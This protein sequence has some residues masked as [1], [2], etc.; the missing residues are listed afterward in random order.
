MSSRRHGLPLS[1]TSHLSISA[2]GCDVV[3]YGKLGRSTS[4]MDPKT[5]ATAMQ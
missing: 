4:E 1:K 5:E 3:Q 2:N